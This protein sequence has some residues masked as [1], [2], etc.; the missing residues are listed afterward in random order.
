MLIGH[1]SKI[2]QEVAGIT[3]A[4]AAFFSR[5]YGSSELRRTSGVRLII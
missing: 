3:A 4:Q 5:N 1:A 2:G